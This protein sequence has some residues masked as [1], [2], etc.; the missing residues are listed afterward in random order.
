M[1][2]GRL[3]Y[4]LESAGWSFQLKYNSN[5]LNSLGMSVIEIGVIQSVC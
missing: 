5:Y 3:I 1:N 2:R 4:F